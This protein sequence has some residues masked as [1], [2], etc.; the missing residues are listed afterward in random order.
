MLLVLYF[1]DD[2]WVHVPKWVA[3][4]AP[5]AALSCHRLAVACVAGFL[6]G[7]GA[8][9][10]VRGWAQPELGA[11]EAAGAGVVRG[12]RGV[13]PQARP[14]G[15]ATGEAAGECSGRLPAK[16][17]GAAAGA[18]PSRAAAG[19]GLRATVALERP[20][21]MGPPLLAFWSSVRRWRVPLLVRWGSA[22]CPSLYRPRH[23]FE[24]S[25]RFRLQ[26]PDGPWPVQR[27]ARHLHRVQARIPVRSLDRYDEKQEQ[28]KSP[29]EDEPQWSG[30]GSGASSVLQGDG[31]SKTRIARREERR[32]SQP[33]EK[34]SGQRAT[35]GHQ[36]EKVEWIWPNSRDVQ[37]GRTTI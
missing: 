21:A 34:N 15:A 13:T 32:V 20:G 35:D 18:L 26:A 6:A 36:A 31:L 17:Y 33:L 28:E 1:S 2:W 24:A 16:R 30:V 14:V 7:V 4:R 29:G 19:E 3:S 9:A 37:A 23:S 22:P 5:A 12:W 10:G 8:A 27:R 11:G 25:G